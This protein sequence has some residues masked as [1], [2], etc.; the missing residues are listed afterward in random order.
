MKLPECLI[1]RTLVVTTKELEEIRNN[2]FFKYG[3]NP[4][5]EIISNDPSFFTTVKYTFDAT[6]ITQECRIEEST[7][8]PDFEYSEK[9]LSLS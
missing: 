6:N 4:S 7:N 2:Y 8:W 5:F 3:I 1:D 9:E